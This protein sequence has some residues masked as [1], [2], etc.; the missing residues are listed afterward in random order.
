MFTALINKELSKYQQLKYLLFFLL[1][2][3]VYAQPAKDVFLIKQHQTEGATSDLSKQTTYIFK[4]KNVIVKYNPVSLV[5]GG[6]L[7]LYQRV[8]SPQISAGCAYEISCSNFSKQCIKHFGLIKGVALS[9]DRL[10]RCNRISSAD[11]HPVFLNKNN[12]M[13]DFPEMYKLKR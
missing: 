11:F 3:S 2:S 7:F 10:T 9:T 12:R 13:I 8:V 1:G 4:N 6:S 5:L